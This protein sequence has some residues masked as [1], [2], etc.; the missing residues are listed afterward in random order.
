MERDVSKVPPVARWSRPGFVSRVFG[1]RKAETFAI[2][3]KPND[4]IPIPL[5]LGNGQLVWQDGRWNNCNLE[6]QPMNHH[7]AAQERAALQRENAEL[8]IECEILLHML[9]VS[10]MNKSR[11]QKKLD[12]LR[13]KIAE[14]LEEIDTDSPS[15]SS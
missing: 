10:E 8:Q 9:T 5:V 4:N 1:A 3:R 12:A 2:D 7:P 13:D 6:V 14:S 15:S 11:L